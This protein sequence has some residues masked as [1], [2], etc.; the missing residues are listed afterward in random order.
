ME[1]STQNILRTDKS[2]SSKFKSTTKSKFLVKFS[3]TMQISCEIFL[4][5]KEQTFHGDIALFF[6]MPCFPPTA[7]CRLGSAP[8]TASRH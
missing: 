1:L 8:R 2:S 3:H 7:H 5:Q 4:R 6:G